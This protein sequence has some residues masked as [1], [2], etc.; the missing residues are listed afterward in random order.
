MHSLGRQ[1]EAGAG[2]LWTAWHFCVQTHIFPSCLAMLS[3]KPVTSSSDC[4]QG[5]RC[6]SVAVPKLTP[7]LAPTPTST[8]PLVVWF[9]T[10]RKAVLDLPKKKKKSDPW[11]KNFTMPL[12][13]ASQDLS[14]AMTPGSSLPSLEHLKSEREEPHALYFKNSQWQTCFM[15]KMGWKF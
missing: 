7:P 12:C 2:L 10:Y 14:K 13:L 3:W 15:L 1:S 5:L 6:Q 11:R 4:I 8:T 9:P